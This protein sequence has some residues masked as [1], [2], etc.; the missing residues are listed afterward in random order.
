MVLG[1]I[2]D[3][4][5]AFG[6]SPLYE[7][8]VIAH[9]GMHT[10][11]GEYIAGIKPEVSVN[12]HGWVAFIGTIDS[13]NQLMVGREALNPLNLSQSPGGRNFG[14]PQI[15]NHNRVVSRELYAGNSIVRVWNVRNPG[16]YNII[17]STAP[18]VFSQ[19]TNPTLGNTLLPTT[20]PNVG[21]LG[22]VGDSTFSYYVN[23]TGV[24]N[25]QDL[26]SPLTG[27]VLTSFRSMAAAIG[28]RTFVAQY[29]TRNDNGR[30]VVFDDEDGDLLWDATQIATTVGGDW[31]DL[32]TAAGIS[33]S[34][35]IV[36]FVGDHLD[37][38]PGIY[39][40]VADPR[41]RNSFVVHR[42][43]GEHDLIAYDENANPITFEYFDFMNRVGVLHQELGAPGYDDDSIVVIFTAKP[44]RASRP[45]PVVPD[46]PFLFSEHMGIWTLRVDAER[47]LS[48][49]NRL[50]IDQFHVTSPIPVVQEGDWIDGGTVDAL[51][52][53]DPLSLAP[54]G[55]DLNPRTPYRGDHFAA[56]SALTRDGVKVVRAALLDTDGDGLMDHWETR[57]IDIDWD[58]N[59]ELDL[60]KMGADPFHK[61]LFLE[62][63]WA[64]DRTEGGHKNWANKFPPYTAQ[65]MAEMFDM[66]PVPN[67][68]GVDGITLHVDAGPGGRYAENPEAR[69]TM[70]G[71][72]TFIPDSVNMGTNPDLM[73]GGDAVALEN[74]PSA[75]LDVVYFGVPLDF[76]VPGVKMRALHDIKDKHFGDKDKWAR[77]FAFNYTFLADYQLFCTGKDKKIVVARVLAATDDT[78]TSD[79]TL[80]T[81][82]GKYDSV[83]ITSGKGAGQVRSVS[84][85]TEGREVDLREPWDVVPD[86]SS[87]F[88]LI[89]S[90]VGGMAEVFFYGFPDYHARPGNDF[91]MSMTVYGVNDGGWLAN[92]K[93]L[94]RIMSHELGHTLGLRHGGTD[95]RNHKPDYLSIMNYRYKYTRRSYSNWTDAVFDDWGYLK[96][97]F[98]HTGYHFGNSYHKEMLKSPNPPDPIDY[99]PLMGRPPDLTKPVV[100]MTAPTD[101]TRIPYGHDLTV[102]LIATD[103][104]GIDA[105]FAV[106]DKDGDGVVE[107]PDERMQAAHIQNGHFSATFK[108]VGG[109]FN[110]RAVMGLAFDTSG[111]IGAAVATVVAGDV[112]GAENILHQSD[113]DFPAQPAADSGGQR[114]EIEIPGITVPGSGRLTFTASSAPP[115][116]GAAGEHERHDTTVSRIRLN[117]KEYALTPVCNPPGSDPAICTSYWQAPTGGVLTVYLLGPAVFDAQGKFLGHPTQHYNLTVTFELVDITL[118]GVSIVEP[119]TGGFVELGETLA[120]QVSATDDY[121]VG[122]V[123][124][125]FDI[126]G[127]GSQDGA[128]E[129]VAAEDLGEGIYR[130]TF[131]GVAG[132]AGARS[133]RVVATDTSGNSTRETGFV[134]VR[135][136][137]TEAPFVAIKSPLAGWPIEQDD[138]LT[139]EVNAYDDVELASV[140]ITFDID[141]DGATSGE[142]ESILAEKTGVNL[143]TA[144]FPNIT[145]PNGSRTVNVVAADTS[146]NTSP[147]DVPVTVGGVEPTI[148]TIFTDTGHIDAQPSVWSGGRQQ[149][150]DYDP[151]AVS[152]SGTLT[153]I[154]TATPPVRREVQNISRAD[155][156]V[157]HIN[158]NGT[159]Y[160][161]TASCNAYGADPSVCTTTFEA[162]ESGTLDFEVLGPGTWNIWG[163]FSGH[164]AQDYTIEIQFT[165]VDITR[166]EVTFTSPD[167]G[168]EVDLGIPLTVDVSIVDE[169]EVAS[170][171]VSFDVD[172]D[173]DTDDFGEQLA[174]NRIAGDNYQAT[175]AD[176]SGIPGARTIEVLA[177]D[178]S[179]NMTRKAMTVG[180][181]GVGAGETVLSALSGTIPGQPSQW[182]GGSRQIVEFDP[183]TVP[184]MGRITFVVTATPNVRQEVQNIERHDPKVVTINFEGQDISLIPVCN[185]PGSD[186][187]VCVSV[188]DSPGAGELDFEILGPA[189]YNIWGEFQGHPEQDYTIE[190]L[191]LPGPTVTEVTPN[192]GSVGGHETVTVR[193]TGFGLNAV[194][195][196]GEVPATDVV[197]ISDEELTCTTPPGVT[198]SVSVIVLNADPEGLSWNYGGPYG[199]FGELKD[200]FTYQPAS[201]PAPMQAER[202]LGTY[203]GYFPAVGSEE[204]QQQETFDFDIPGSGRV[205]FEAYAFIPILNAIPGPFEDPD[206]LEWHNESTAVRSFKGGDGGGHWTQ[207]E[208]TDLNYA[209]G[210]VISDATR[211]VG[212]G[213]AGSG[214]LTVKGPARWNAFWRQFGEY[215][216]LSAP[217]QNWSLAVWYAEPPSLT[218]VFPTSGTEAGG[219]T[220]TLTGSNFAEGIKV[221]FDGALATNVVVSNENTLTCMTPP[222]LAGLAS[223]EVELLDMTAGLADAF[224]Y[225]PDVQRKAITEFGVD[226]QG[227]PIIGVQTQVGR[228]YQLQ[229][230]DDLA[231]PN[232]WVDVG[233][234]FAGSGGEESVTDPTLAPYAP[235]M[236]YRFIIRE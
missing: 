54:V 36:A 9:E 145:G 229:R 77:E 221:R 196:F 2:F 1:L 165:S 5:P 70:Y 235:G 173:G 185:S 67:P 128:G 93:I 19:L 92:Y 46:E 236:F 28:T 130:A 69:H 156:Y 223:V 171:V 144:E 154:V 45:N 33:D 199:L 164:H 86:A 47:E 12:E 56:F 183:I 149:V 102:S 161:L 53:Y 26:V 105:V 99:E 197:W 207:V 232:G 226:P 6:L 162:T 143:Y 48:P 120:V 169:A 225:E 41:F 234:E 108:D 97:D 202:L 138:T 181:G 146:M 186:P 13:G 61:D 137:D 117:D 208:Y 37:D 30:I 204:P 167:M 106:F 158:F 194:A 157:R 142:G 187:A 82:F 22:R 68:D 191:F 209:Y 101:G 23:D 139:V 57:G 114:Q 60:P 188:W 35:R 51:T 190:V 100:I 174:A 76:D 49:P 121:G 201:P 216:M 98:H 111:N 85:I 166:P 192:S 75:H 25:V 21:F 124:I 78:L 134:E 91:I 132:D 219:D 182:N 62:V 195:L 20:S 127:D 16:A 176:L 15:N 152:G 170:V 116:R 205:R 10:V 230:N 72:V 112:S 233:G 113:G 96:Y 59:L 44:E 83:L 178:T 153:F 122:A 43:F 71:Y 103:D 50:T 38:G 32:G 193:G 172:G 217:A 220:V 73:C 115:V 24:R 88:T 95:H 203:K 215:V 177:T 224:T 14:Y 160:N 141:G 52:L 7:Y 148:E 218:S 8:T 87:T 231:N 159:D 131:A 18:S 155:P 135:V 151:I 4:Q 64:I 65:G 34:G 211:V 126:D 168:A 129:T 81:S 175:F 189:T 213:A 227:S 94:W 74:D 40:A 104:S 79:T 27:T 66:A 119:P 125:A 55:V 180:V 147:A 140:T 179:F 110:T 123:E 163:E 228:T 150:I 90:S 63:D 31:L 206:N 89:N 42:I 109:P 17:A 3:Q 58:G 200:G 210:P 39:L 198:S 118:P 184:G 29:S 136:P 212:S 84:R 11:E 222:G 107:D 214:Q 133:I 80:P